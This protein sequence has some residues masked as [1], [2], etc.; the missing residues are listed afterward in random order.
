MEKFW[1]NYVGEQFPTYASF[2]QAIQNCLGDLKRFV[3]SRKNQWEQNILLTYDRV[4]KYLALKRKLNSLKVH[5]PDDEI[6]LD[7]HDF[8]LRKDFL[9]DFI[10]FDGDFYNIVYQIQKF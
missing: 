5:S 2:N 8:N 10:T 6:V 3:Y 9:L 4:K 7:A 1:D